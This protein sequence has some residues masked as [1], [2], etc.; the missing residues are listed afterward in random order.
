MVDVN[1]EV[2]GEAA[3]GNLGASLES[4]SMQFQNTS[5]SLGSIF[6]VILLMLFA[7]FFIGIGFGVILRVK[8]AMTGH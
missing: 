7:L 2:L 3:I 6:V 5:V 8:K 1:L 4:S